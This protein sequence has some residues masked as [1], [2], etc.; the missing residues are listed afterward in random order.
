VKEGIGKEMLD[1][2]TQNELRKKNICFNYKE[3]WAPGH[4]CMGKGKVH[5]IEVHS[6]S[7]EEENVAPEQGNEQGE[8]NEENL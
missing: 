4:I 2:A 3:P 5:Y 1:E 6:N 8:Y 7:D